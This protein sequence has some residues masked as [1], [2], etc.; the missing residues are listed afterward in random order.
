MKPVQLKD[1]SVNDAIDTPAILHF[2]PL[3]FN[4]TSSKELPKKNK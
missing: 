4:S 1:N 2:S 3:V